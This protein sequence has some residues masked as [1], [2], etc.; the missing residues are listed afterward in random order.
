MKIKEYINSKDSSQNPV[1][2]WTCIMEPILK[3]ER[4]SKMFYQCHPIQACAGLEL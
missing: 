4:Q 1:Y 2:V 3:N